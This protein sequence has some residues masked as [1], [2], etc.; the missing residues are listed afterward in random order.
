MRWS[1]GSTASQ[2]TVNKPGKYWVE[3]RNFQ[4]CVSS[5]TVA[6]TPC[7]VPNI[8]TPNGDQ[9]NETFFIKGLQVAQWNLEI[10]NRWGR[11]VYR[12]NGYDNSWDA[13]GQ[14]NGVYYY[15][16]SSPASGQRLKGYIEVVR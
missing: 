13:Q 14:S 3:V 16:L 11:Q 10:Y 9:Q 6:V 2:L 1:D 7:V 4:G 8:I 15:L 5:D 12:K